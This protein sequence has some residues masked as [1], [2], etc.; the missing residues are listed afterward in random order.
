MK[1]KLIQFL[2]W[3]LDKLGAEYYLKPQQGYHLPESVVQLLPET[4]TVVMAVQIQNPTQSGEWKL[5]QAYAKLIKRNP[6]AS[7]RDISLAIALAVR[8]L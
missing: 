7:R 3:F 2:F 5:H 8:E 1:R 6:A 4:R